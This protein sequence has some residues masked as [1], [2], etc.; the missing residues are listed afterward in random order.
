[1]TMEPMDRVTHVK[2]RMAAMAIDR[3]LWEKIWDDISIY[4]LPDHA[5]WYPGS[6]AGTANYDAFARGPVAVERGRQRFDDT[7]LRAVDR[8]GAGMESLVTPQSEKWHGLAV[9]DPLAP[10][11]TDEETEY[12]EHYRD[13]MFKVRY[14]PK[15]GFIGAHQKALRAATALGTGIVYM[16]EAMGAQ[17]HI[18]PVVYRFLPLSECYLAVDAQGI[19]DTCYR[20]FSMTARQMVQRFGS[21]A[22]HERVRT[23]ASQP[24]NMDKP[25]RVIHAVEPRLDYNGNGG[26]T[27][28]GAPFSSCYV[29]SDNSVLIGESGFFEFPFVVYYWQPVDNQAYAQSPIMLAL[30]EIKGLNVMTKASLKGLQSYMDPPW[31]LYHEGTMNRLNLNPG[32]MNPGFLDSTGRPRA[33]ALTT[34]ANPQFIQEILTPGRDNVKDALYVTLFQ[35]LLNN[36]NMTATE[37]MIRANE[38]GELLGPAGG[39]IQ[40]AMAHEVERMGGILHRKGAMAP[41]APLA[42]PRSLAGKPYGASFTSPLDRLRKSAERLGIQESM[43]TALPLMQIDPSVADNFDLDE[44]VRTDTEATAAPHKILRSIEERDAKRQARQ[45]QQQVQQALEMAKTGGE[46]AKNIV[47]AMQGMSQLAGLPGQPP[48]TGPRPGA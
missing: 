41:G 1:M 27:T 36:P 6:S 33:Q 23:W 11:A 37:A 25:V 46:A 42:P 5:R 16:E 4:C 32:K 17:A 47:P 43:Q 8:L 29:D 21:D 38:K 34:G 9:N 48:P 30:S 15:S 7:A 10:E 2:R 3:A 14:N 35:I 20:N 22:V 18:V 13:Y 39:K 19:T 44:L 24:E 12:F 40:Y 26:G 28:K 31:A 45:Q